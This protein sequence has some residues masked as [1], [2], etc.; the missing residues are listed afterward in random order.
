MTQRLLS[1]AVCA[2][3]FGTAPA[4]ASSAAPAVDTPQHYD[5]T[6]QVLPD[7]HQLK[8]AGTVTLPATNAPR[9]S[10]RL[11]LSEL[12]H[13]FA[14]DVV[15]SRA[16]SGQARLEK[17]ETANGTTAWIVH[18]PRAVPAGEP[19]TLRFTYAGGEKVAFVFYIGPEGTF[20]GGGNTAW[21]PHLEDLSI[22]EG[23]L[24]LNVP[25][26]YTAVATGTRRS[27]ADEERRGTF[28]F[29]VAHA[30]DIAFAM[31]KFIVVRRDGP[32]P[33]VAYLLRPRANVD[34]YLDGC[35]KA[36]GFLSQEYGPYPYA[37]FALVEVPDKQAEQANF[38]GAG[39]AGLILSN[40]SSL[41]APFSM[42]FYAHEIGH[43]W[44][45]NSITVAGDRGSYMLSEG[46]AQYGSLQAVEAFEGAASAERYRRTGYPDYGTVFQSGLGYLKLAAAGFD[47]PLSSL[48]RD[49]GDGASF[50]FV[51]HELADGKGFLVLDLLSRTIGRERFRQVLTD[52]TARHAFQPVTWDDFV[53]AVRAGAGQNVDWFFAQWF[54]RTGAPDWHLS[55]RRDGN[56]VHGT[57]VQDA[58][59]FRAEVELEA[60]GAHGERATRTVLI[61]GARTEFSWP[62]GFA[63]RDIALDPHFEVLH[64]T[65]EYRAEATGLVTYYRSA[66]AKRETSD[67]EFAALL[68]TVPS[69]DTYGLRFWMEYGRAIALM[70]TKPAEARAHFEA[71]LTS[72]VK[73]ARGLPRLYLWLATVDHTLHDEA[74]MRDAAAKALAADQASGNQANI[75]EQVQ[76][77][78]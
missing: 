51:A 27:T 14:V 20:A 22:G 26:G 23:T 75:A 67:A 38:G 25:A 35:V 50:G 24:V 6:V 17:G 63:V 65:P 74:G 52:F 66:V 43:M 60:V 55:W 19:V 57:I 37:E 68:K 77:L 11:E 72:R 40:G 30:V 54:E 39:G 56:G 76:A 29:E 53:S 58:P 8:V 61:D 10:I 7:Q 44:W 33:A 41:D 13:D 59:Y 3:L 48:P 64:W 16:P 36:L 31:A 32:V 28:R 47:R 45:G 12:M 1:I 2:A 62:A 49:T 5:L 42:A 21:Y 18:T 69:P 73:P 4:M 34:A 15:S 71:A 9:D 78:W 46:M 70:D